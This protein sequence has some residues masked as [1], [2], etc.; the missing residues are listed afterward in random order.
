MAICTMMASQIK[1]SNCEMS[2]D[3]SVSG[4]GGPG[5]PGTLGG[6]APPPVNPFIRI[7]RTRQL[8]KLTSVL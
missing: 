1:M 5:R 8:G 7:D 4:C 2:G 3:I 6:A